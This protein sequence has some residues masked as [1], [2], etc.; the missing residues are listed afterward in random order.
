MTIIQAKD[1]QIIA[2]HLKNLDRPVKIINFT[3]ELECQYC[4]ETR[5]LMEELARMSEKLSIEVYNFQ[6]DKD[7]VEQY[8]ID[9]IPATVI[10]GEKDYGVRFYGIPAGYEFVGLLEGIIAVSKGQSGLNE[11]TRQIL[12]NITKPVHFQVF[13][14]PTCPYCPSAVRLAHAFA[15]ENEHITA[16]MVEITEFPHLGNRYGVRGV[17]KTVI[18]ENISLEGA[19]PEYKLIE[20]LNRALG[21]KTQDRE[22]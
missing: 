21:N 14:T 6:I 8:K 18:N 17:P 10:E 7:R 11:K 22:E 1:K 9:K 2:D 19:V 15:I 20:E 4:R 16:D 3:Q 13:V 12:K 5:Q